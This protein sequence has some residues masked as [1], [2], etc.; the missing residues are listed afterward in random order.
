[1]IELTSITDLTTQDPAIDGLAFPSTPSDDFWTTTPRAGTT[2]NH[3]IV[4]FLWGA[5]NS[6]ISTALHYAR[7]MRDPT[8]RTGQRYTTDTQMVRDS[9][10][11][12]TWQRNP[13]NTQSDFATTSQ[14]CASLTIGT[15][16]DFR[17]PTR[18]ELMSIVDTSQNV[19]VDTAVFGLPTGVNYFWSQ[20]RDAGTARQWFVAFREGGTPYS[21]PLTNAGVRCVM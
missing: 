12:L 14:Y 10:T 3:W 13:S 18:N 2:T 16:A 5:P 1:M 9:F 8:A 15:L 19:A 6:D 11:G 4:T 20:S 17:L 7:C 21:D